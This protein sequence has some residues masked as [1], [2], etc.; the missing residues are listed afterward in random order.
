MRDPVG[1]T[2]RAAPRVDTAVHG[3]RSR[4]R[5]AA[6]RQQIGDLER[7]ARHGTD[8]QRDVDL[9]VKAERPA[10]LHRQLQHGE[11]APRRLARSVAVVARSYRA[12]GMP[13]GPEVLHPR[14]FEVRKVRG[15]VHDSHRIGLGEARAQPVTERVVLPVTRRLQGQSSHALR[16]TPPSGRCRPLWPLRPFRPTPSGRRHLASDSRR[17]R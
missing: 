9:V 15:V 14:L 2:R 12:V 6:D 10:V 11:L 16:A 4:L 5:L 3:D 13:N 17:P 8:A 7:G 1:E